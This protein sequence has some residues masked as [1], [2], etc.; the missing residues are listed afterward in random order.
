M[1]EDP[2]PFEVFADGT[3][4]HGTGSEFEPGDQTRELLTWTR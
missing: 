1:S 2:T 4:L 3:D